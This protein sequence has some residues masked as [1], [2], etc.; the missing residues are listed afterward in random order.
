MEPK[1][2]WFN[3]IFMAPHSFHVLTFPLTQL[4]F[5]VRCFNQSLEYTLNSLV[6]LLLCW[7]NLANLQPLL[8]LTFP[9]PF[10]QLNEAR[11]KHTTKLTG[12]ILNFWS[13]ISCGPFKL[14]SNHTI[15][16]EAIHSVT[17]LEGDCFIPFLLFSTL[18]PLISHPDCH[19]NLLPIYC[20]NG[21]HQ[22]RTF[23]S[24][25]NHMY[26]PT[27]IW[28]HRLCLPSCSCWWTLHTLCKGNISTYKLD[29]TPLA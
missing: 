23:T 25:H 2:H 28:A 18:Q 16:P 1:I 3:Y 19:G 11:E 13:L 27:S 6:L 14:P 17:L 12:L 26:P 7:T 21:S 29:S 15:F 22:K 5:V 9:T 4:K 24:S 10:A 8:N 20:E